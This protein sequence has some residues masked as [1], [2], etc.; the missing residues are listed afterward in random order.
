MLSLH[1]LNTVVPI[2][3]EEY[4]TFHIG[5]YD[6]FINANSPKELYIASL[7]LLNTVK[8]H[9]SYSFMN[10]LSQLPDIKIFRTKKLNVLLKCIHHA[11]P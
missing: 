9:H 8:A 5:I 11:K 10:K 2:L 4:S 1:A 3:K 7:T 6:I